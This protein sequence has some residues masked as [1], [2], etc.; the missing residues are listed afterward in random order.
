MF[1]EFGSL[2]SGKADP[3]LNGLIESGQY[4]K[5]ENLSRFQQQIVA[6]SGYQHYCSQAL[7][8]QPL[9]FFSQP[10]ATDSD[11]GCSLQSSDVSRRFGS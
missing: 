7:R 2:Y 4:L 5:L 8:S 11:S 3:R 9:N 1:D 10:K 6:S